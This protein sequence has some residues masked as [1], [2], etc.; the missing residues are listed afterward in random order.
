MLEGETLQ[1]DQ[2][3]NAET[4]KILA[5]P[6]VLEKLAFEGSLPTPGTAQQFAA[7]IQSEHAKW[8]K[9]P[10]S[11]LFDKAIEYGRKGFLVSPTIAGQ[12]AA[13]VP[14]L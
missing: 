13:Q 7:R 3:P 10:F 8:G 1:L 4:V 14:I 6:D 5:R 9:L 2:G 11:R 12:W